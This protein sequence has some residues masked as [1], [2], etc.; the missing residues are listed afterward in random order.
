MIIKL[1]SK[2]LK[3]SISYDIKIFDN[4]DAQLKIIGPG[5]NMSNLPREAILVSGCALV[6]KNIQI[7]ENH[8]IDVLDSVG[9]FQQLVV[10]LMEL[11]ASEG[12][13]KTVFPINKIISEQTY[14]IKTTTQSANALF[15]APWSAKIDLSRDNKG[16]IIYKID[17]IYNKEGENADIHME[18]ML[19]NYGPKNINIPISD[20]F[21]ISEWKQ[22]NVGLYSKKMENGTMHDFGTTFIEKPYKTLG[23]LRKYIKDKYH[24]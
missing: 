1:T 14:P 8:A 3:Q 10:T 16:T 4:R 6:T 11:S 18:G 24:K 17:F 5:I 20:D 9:L 7:E 13:D 15:N 21:N 19:S 23:E 22:Y 12:P 2:Q